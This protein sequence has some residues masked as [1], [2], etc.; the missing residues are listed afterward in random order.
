MSTT[1]SI[2]RAATE[3]W[4]ATGAACPA[5]PT[6]SPTDELAIVTRK[7]AAPTTDSAT[8]TIANAANHGEDF[9]GPKKHVVGKS[10]TVAKSSVMATPT[11][12]R[13]SNPIPESKAEDEI[14][15]NMLGVGKGNFET[16]TCSYKSKAIPKSESVPKTTWADIVSSS[17]ARQADVVSLGQAHQKEVDRAGVDVFEVH[18]VH[19]GSPV[20]SHRDLV[21]R[22]STPQ[23]V[24]YFGDVAKPVPSRAQDKMLREQ[25][26]DARKDAW[27]KVSVVRN[28]HA[29]SPS[30]RLGHPPD[31]LARGSSAP[32]S[33]LHAPQNAAAV[34]ARVAPLPVGEVVAAVRGRRLDA[35]GATRTGVRVGLPCPPC[36]NCLPSLPCL[37]ACPD[38]SPL[39]ARLACPKGLPSALPARRHS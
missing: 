23:R 30:G 6:I 38:W 22:D 11:R 19:G 36:P 17:K 12:A 3:L 7:L 5:T 32:P 37:P 16:P 8:Q 29:R 25:R 35:A 15:P 39:A 21:D 31:R 9:V 18:F 10:D 4:L 33:H 26:A 1:Q 24:F 14:G 2:V 20:R 28:P 34:A 13:K 27:T